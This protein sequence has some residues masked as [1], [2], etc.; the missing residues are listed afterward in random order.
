[1]PTQLLPTIRAFGRRLITK[2]GI[3]DLI[4]GGL[5]SF[6]RA[7]G[8]RFGG[9]EEFGHSAGEDGTPILFDPSTASWSFSISSV[10]AGA[11]VFVASACHAVIDHEGRVLEWE[12]GGSFAVLNASG[13]DYLL[14][15]KAETIPASVVEIL[16]DP[17]S[18]DYD[19]EEL[20]VGLTATPDAVTDLGSGVLRIQIDVL[21]DAS[22]LDGSGLTDSSVRVYLTAFADGGPGPATDSGWFEDC[23]IKFVGGAAVI[24]T[25]SYLGQSTPS[26]TAADYRVTLLGPIVRR[27]ATG[28]PSGARPVAEWTGAGAG[29]PPTSA[30]GVGD[31]P[32]NFTAHPVPARG[33]TYFLELLAESIAALVVEVDGPIYVETS[34]FTANTPDGATVPGICYR[35]PNVEEIDNSSAT[36]AFT[37]KTTVPAALLNDGTT[38]LRIHGE[39]RMGASTDGGHATVSVRMQGFNLLSEQI[40]SFAP[41]DGLRFDLTVHVRDDGDFMTTG[42]IDKEQGGT[43]NVKWH[44]FENTS[45]ASGSQAD[46]DVEV[47]WS[48]TGGNNRAFLEQFVVEVAR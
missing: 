24:D 37:N 18:Y 14:G 44:S 41:F 45:I 3:N 43:P 16:D 6:A 38:I 13:V 1:M 20:V 25:T 19:S 46:V 21:M 39:V 30:A 5:E 15:V 11:L 9:T 23:A 7:I 28:L 31:D 47:V 29:N 48:A 33:G 26:T 40:S 12:H 34:S 8:Y 42:F 4:V 35:S 10:A 2:A 17:G 32:S 22:E 27:V 36:V